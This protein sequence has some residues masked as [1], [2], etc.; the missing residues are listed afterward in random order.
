MLTAI[1]LYFFFLHNLPVSYVM[2]F[3]TNHVAIEVAPES[4]TLRKPFVIFY[5]F[6][7][8][9]F[10][11]PQSK[12]DVHKPPPHPCFLS[13]IVVMPF[14]FIILVGSYYDF[15]YCCCSCFFAVAV[16]VILQFP[17]LPPKGKFACKRAKDV[18]AEC[19]T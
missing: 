19:K 3:H 5:I 1:F 8:F 18:K 7:Y 6:F 12:F 11:T 15:C 17:Q 16:V 2:H 9:L 10:L 4:K 14:P 13:G